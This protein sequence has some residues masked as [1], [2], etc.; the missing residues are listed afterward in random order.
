MP[1]A[2]WKS[3]IRRSTADGDKRGGIV[4]GV[5]RIIA[6]LAREGAYDSA[7]VP[8]ATVSLYPSSASW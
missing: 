1:A 6:K 3:N 2:L 7:P 8:Y 4:L 5:V